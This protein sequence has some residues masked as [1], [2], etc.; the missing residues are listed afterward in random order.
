MILQGN[1]LRISAV[2]VDYA[3]RVEI[4]ILC[5]INGSRHV[6]KPLTLEWDNVG[7]MYVSEPT[8]SMRLE[9]AQGLMQSLWDAGL[10]PN[11]GEGGSA[12]ADAMR[13]HIQFAEHVSRQLLGTVAPNHV[14]HLKR[15]P[16][17]TIADFLNDDT[18]ARATV[19]AL[20]RR[21]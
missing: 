3:L 11:S 9:V 10:R 19:C 18:S 8:F 6:A 4:A 2:M 20:L 13:N 16:Y 5:E 21:D 17:E 14:M 7:D 12:Q 1:N 15:I